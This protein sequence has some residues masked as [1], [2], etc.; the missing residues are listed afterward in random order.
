MVPIFQRK[1]T[2]LVEDFQKVAGSGKQITIKDYIARATAVLSLSFYPPHLSS[3]FSLL[4]N[5]NRMLLAKLRSDI[6]LIHKETI[7]LRLSMKFF[8][9]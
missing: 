4:L 9:L 2:L 3:S 1:G 6:S 8:Q 7:H 5:L